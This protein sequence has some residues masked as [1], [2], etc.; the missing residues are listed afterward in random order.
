MLNTNYLRTVGID[1]STI[2]R[3]ERDISVIQTTWIEDYMTI[4]KTYN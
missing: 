1:E 2:R 4:L 3:M